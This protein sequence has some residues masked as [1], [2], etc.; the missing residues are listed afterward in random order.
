[1]A[2]ALD[3]RAGVSNV[4]KPIFVQ[5]FVAKLSVERFDESVFDR[6]A[7]ANV[8]ERNVGVSAPGEHRSGSQ[9]GTVVH[10]DVF[11]FAAFE[12]YSVKNAGDALA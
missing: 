7:R 6:L 12:N 3:F 10:D 11:R 5:A 9:F 2:P 4:E 8:F 1:M